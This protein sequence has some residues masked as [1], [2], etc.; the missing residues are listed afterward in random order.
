[1]SLP[2]VYLFPGFDLVSFM[3][4]FVNFYAL[5]LAISISLNLEFGYAGIPNFGKVL[6]IAGG[7]AFSGSISG[8]LASYVLNIGS[9]QDFIVFS[10][11]IVNQID[12]VLAHDPVFAVELFII[13][14]MIGALIGALFGYLA[15]YPA[16]R[17]RED[18]LGMLLLGMAQFFQ[19]VMRTFTPLTGGSQNIAVP[20]PYFYWISL[21]T[22]WRDLVA[23][24]V[25]SAL[26]ILVFIYAERVA[27]SPLGRM[28]K[29]VRESEDAARA[30]GKDD[31]V[32]RRNVLIV[33]SAISGIIGAVF[34]M[35]IAS[36]EYD[37]WN[38][39][40][41][42]FWPF[43]I[44]IIGG[45]GNNY[46]VALGAAFFSFVLKGLE[47]I[48]PVLQPYVFFD[49][50]WLQ[51]LLFAVLLITILMLRPEGIIKEK[52]APT[53]PKKT[54]GALVAGQGDPPPSGGAKVQQ[55][56][57]E[58]RAS[59]IRRLFELGRRTSPIAD[60]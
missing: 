29:A 14:V 33:A 44:V 53:L 35:Y 16:I 28:L 19:V 37:T 1:M 10:T 9:H 30:L 4:G 49:A 36:V 23:G 7:A 13:S 8:R 6:F 22:G 47:Q 15:S 24:L 25:M 46:G 52:S 20:D 60:G 34:T 50:N 2:I 48:Q 11:R 56:R 45:V 17:L 32:V 43:L 59:R 5:Y 3:V 18:Y 39:V 41:W 12:G 27:K 38:R 42:T 31:A 54:L 55:A 21:G 58:G 51:Y 57:T 26:A 40:A